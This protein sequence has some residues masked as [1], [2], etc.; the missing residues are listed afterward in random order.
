MKRLWELYWWV[1]GKEYCRRCI[2]DEKNDAEKIWDKQKRYMRNLA[3]GGEGMVRDDQGNEYH[4]IKFRKN[5]KRPDP[6]YREH[7][8]MKETLRFCKE[9]KTHRFDAIIKDI[10]GGMTNEQLLSKYKR[11]GLD[12]RLVTVYRKV[13]TGNYSRGSATLLSFEESISSLNEI[14]PA[15]RKLG[16]VYHNIQTYDSTK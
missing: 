1:D 3:A 8:E 5:P 11:M 12:A 15:S 10:K 9:N 6:T 2:S 16:T 7:R 4:F 13:A 14:F